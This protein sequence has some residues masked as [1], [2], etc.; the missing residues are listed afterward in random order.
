MEPEGKPEFVYYDVAAYAGF[1]R[2]LVGIVIDLVVLLVFYGVVLAV[3][4]ADVES[5]PRWVKLTV[6]GIAYL[7]L[8]VFRRSR[9]R[10]PGYWATDV[11]IVDLKGRRPSMFLMTMRLLWWVL[12]PINPIIDFVF[13]SNDDC[14]QTIR[15]KLLGTYVIRVCAEPAGRGHRAHDRVGFV[16]MMLVCPVVVPEGEDATS[17]PTA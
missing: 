7:Y 13:I 9:F 16:G 12:G 17:E 8:T 11:R 5:P 6:A 10:T 1:G 15:D 2:R 3:L 14:N 4:G